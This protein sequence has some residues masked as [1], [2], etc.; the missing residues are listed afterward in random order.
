MPAERQAFRT[1]L[2]LYNKNFMFR[3]TLGICAVAEV[4][5]ILQLSG[6][7]FFGGGFS[8]FACC[9]PVK[10]KVG[11]SFNAR[12]VLLSSCDKNGF[13]RCIQKGFILSLDSTNQAVVPILFKASILHF[14]D[15]SHYQVLG[16]VF[17]HV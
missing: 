1:C 15:F 10:T 5:I 13:E 11:A 3:G 7:V 8:F 6:W 2:K 4:H 17:M 12:A 9:G 14:K 16:C